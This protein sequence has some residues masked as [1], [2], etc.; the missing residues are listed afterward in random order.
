MQAA[1][2]VR[3]PARIAIAAWQVARL[4]P[5]VLG[6]QLMQPDTVEAPVAAL[7]SDDSEVACLAARMLSC[8]AFG[9][10]DP[11]ATEEAMLRLVYPR[12][13][14]P[15]PAP[16]YMEAPSAVSFLIG[17]LNHADHVSERCRWRTARSEHRQPGKRK[18]CCSCST[19]LQRCC[20]WPL[21]RGRHRLSE[22]APYAR[23]ATS[24]RAAMVAG[25]KRLPS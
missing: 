6:R 14:S 24:R 20:S 16:I 1:V 18:C 12:D 3:G 4:S 11:S 17:W 7:Q 25:L 2:H 23:Y 19:A 5:A 15:G 8:F 13:M 9:G 22:A 10:P 21:I